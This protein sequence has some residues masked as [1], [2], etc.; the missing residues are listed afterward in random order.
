M[1]DKKRCVVIELAFQPFLAG[2]EVGVMAFRGLGRGRGNV[3]FF[4]LLE[5]AHCR[6]PLLF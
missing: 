3:G 1:L 4:F 2:V 6:I 5:Q